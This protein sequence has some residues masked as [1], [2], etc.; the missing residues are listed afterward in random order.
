MPSQ[1]S[2]HLVRTFKMSAAIGILNEGVVT[3]EYQVDDPGKITLENKFYTTDIGIQQDYYCWVYPSTGGGHGMVDFLRGVA[4]SC[5]V[6]FYKVGGGYKD[7]VKNGGLG[8]LRLGEYAKA[9]GYAHATGIELP[10]E[11]WGFIPTPDYKRLVQGENWATGDTYIATIGQGLVTSTPI[12]VLMSI[13]TLANNG[14]Y[15]KPT[16]VKEVLDS[17]GHVIQPFQPKQEWD[18]TKDPLITVFDENGDPVPKRDPVTGDIIP[19]RDEN[20]NQMIDDLTGEKLIE[21]EKKTVAPW[22][23]KLAQ[24]GMREVVTIGTAKAQFE[25]FS[26]PSAGKTGTAEYCDDIARV[27]DICKPGHWPAHA[28]YVGYAPADDPEIAV[29]AFVYH[30]LEGSRVAAP[31]VRKVLEAYFSLKQIDKSPTAP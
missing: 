12:Q 4:E 18:I 31:I 6:Y 5:D 14:I 7:E 11:A 25:D 17:E 15:I 30:G 24:E 21:Y 19:R 9:L 16:L 22:V 28:W 27:K 13:A 8:I 3:P 29:V 2:T 23:V 1:R 10:G 26:V 20:G